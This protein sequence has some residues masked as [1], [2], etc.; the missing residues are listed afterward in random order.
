M[1]G[2]H[3]HQCGFKAMDTQTA[4]ILAYASA[5]DGYFFDT[6]IIV[7][8]KRFGLPVTE[9]AVEW[10]EKARKGNSKVNP[11]RDAKK[12]GSD[13]LAFRLG[14]TSNPTIFQ[15]SQKRR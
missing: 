1:D 6:E 12:I 10:S 3:D 5:S 4:R 9:V 11:L 2:V 7:R 8:C 13:M 14:L 15:V